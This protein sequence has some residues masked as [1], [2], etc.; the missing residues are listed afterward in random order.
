MR[1][2]WSRFRRPVVVGA[3]VSALVAGPVVGSAQG[4]PPASP[5]AAAVAM[6]AGRWLQ[7]PLRVER[8][9]S[10]GTT[11]AAGTARDAR[12]A[13]GPDA[14][15]GT[16]SFLAQVRI[17][18]VSAGTLSIWSRGDRRPDTPAIS[19]G[20][21]TSSTTTLVSTDGT[22]NLTL[23]A[24]SGV[25][26]RLTVTGYL[27]GAP[28]ADPGAGGTV[29]VRSSTVVDSSTGAG[30]SVPDAG[31]TAVVPVAGNGPVPVRGA[32]AVWLSVAARGPA[33]GTLAFGTPGLTSAEVKLSTSWST[34][35]VLVPL[36]EDGQLAYSTGGPAPA[37]LRVAVVGAGSA[38]PS[39][40]GADRRC[41]TA[42]CRSRA[43]P[44]RRP[45][46]PRASTPCRSPGVTSRW[47]RRV[48]C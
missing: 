5:A 36:D 30:G 24:S 35:L 26:V 1:L 31:R 10:G 39:P 44:S 27:Q 45:R 18:A 15:R 14:P 33:G 37:A 19:Y 23:L 25:R 47:V 7:V 9:A 41:R 4:A 16:R 38:A 43:V 32:R 21:G 12:L 11:L 42:S 13:A 17:D 8:G 34:S 28:G 6:T 48:P 40:T 46:A 29:V 2:F 20:A 3:M 22:G